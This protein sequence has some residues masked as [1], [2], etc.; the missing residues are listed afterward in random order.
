M[1]PR[2]GWGGYM[3]PLWFGQGEDVSPL[4]DGGS[5]RARCPFWE[6]AWTVPRERGRM[7]FWET[8]GVVQ[9]W[10]GHP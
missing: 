7:L 3:V 4:E 2:T 1:A 6:T 10:F 9:P 5:V 8:Q